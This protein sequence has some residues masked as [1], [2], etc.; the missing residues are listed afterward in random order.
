MLIF[1]ILIIDLAAQGPPLVSVFTIKSLKLDSHG[2]KE[3]NRHVIL[4][5]ITISVLIIPMQFI[6]GFFSE[7][8]NLGRKKVI[9]I[10]FLISSL[11]FGACCL[12]YHNFS[13]LLGIGLSFLEAPATLS[14]VY[15]NEV[16]NT[17]L[18]D[19]ALGFLSYFKSIGGFISQIIYI[20]IRK[21][22]S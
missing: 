3:S 1:I 20:E 13:L 6:G 21:C 16:Y 11:F 14:I 7:M 12:F 18:R 22:I 9:L 2:D 10:C 5:Q 8:K 17:A 4:N 19:M 15:A